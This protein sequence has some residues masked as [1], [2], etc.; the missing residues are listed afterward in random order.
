[1]KTTNRT[2]VPKS[3]PELFRGSWNSNKGL[4]DGIVGVIIRQ[5]V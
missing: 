1:M 4:K 5:N 3:V 2:S